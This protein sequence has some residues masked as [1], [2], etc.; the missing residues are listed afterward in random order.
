MRAGCR[1][2]SSN[3]ASGLE[4]LQVQVRDKEV[5]KPRDDD[6]GWKLLEK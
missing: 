1:A 3:D 5:D 4:K 2:T 6:E